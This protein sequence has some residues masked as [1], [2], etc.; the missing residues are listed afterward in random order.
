M[1]RVECYI[2]IGN[3]TTHGNKRIRKHPH[4]RLQFDWLFTKSMH[5]K[6]NVVYV[7]D[8]PKI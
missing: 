6:E 7:W 2:H 8:R 1:S 5:P 3:E 4:E